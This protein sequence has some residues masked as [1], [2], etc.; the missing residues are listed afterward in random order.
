MQNNSMGQHNKRLSS[1]RATYLSFAGK[2]NLIKSVLSNLPVYYL[3]V[4]KCPIS[5]A[6]CQSYTKATARF[7]LARSR[8]RKEDALGG[9]GTSVQT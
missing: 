8:S 4:F 9:L 2:I 3:L 1:W 6:T 5:F 7:P